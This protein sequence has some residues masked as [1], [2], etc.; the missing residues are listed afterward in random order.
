MAISS[1]TPNRLLLDV[2]TLQINGTDIGATGPE[3]TFV[4]E[5]EIYWPELGGSRGRIAG[6]GKVV[7]ETATLEM[8]LKEV[9]IA[10]LLNALPTLSS[11]SDATSEYTVAENFGSIGTSAHKTVEYVGTT[12][13]SKA[14]R[15]ALY[16]ALPEGGISMNLA[17][18]GETTYTVRFRSYF[19]AANPKQ[20]CWK[21]S[22]AL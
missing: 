18:G 3:G 5:Q 21:M 8:P 14:V 19:T 9:T 13:G 15:I 4:V 2:G 1:N 16:N 20:R 6:T 22:V 11:S 10:N 12:V 17:E 7:R